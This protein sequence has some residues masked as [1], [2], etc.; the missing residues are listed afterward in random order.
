MDAP[1]TR[2]GAASKIRPPM[3][4]VPAALAL[5]L[6]ASCATSKP[7]T[8]PAP[9]GNDRARAAVRALADDYVAA[10]TAT[11]PEVAEANGLTGA[12]PD[13]LSD[14]SLA[15]LAR[16]EAR[17]DAWAAQLSAI[18]GAALWGTPE[19][20][21][22]GL[23]QEDLGARRQ[24]RVCRGELWPMSQ[25]NG[26]Q[27]QLSLLAT[28]QRTGTPELRAAALRRFGRVPTSLDTEIA[29]AREGLRL[30]YSIPRRAAERVLEQ[31]QGLLVPAKESPLFD[32]A[33]RDG[34]PAFAAEWTALLDGQI[35]PAITRYRDFLR[36]EYLPAAR[37]DPSLLK[38]RDG[39][40]C[41]RAQFRAWTTLDRPP[42]ETFRLG[43]ARV[44][45][46]VE[47]AQAIARETL[48]V[49]A[50]PDILG[51]LQADPRN[52]FSSRD[53]LAAFARDSVSRAREAVPRF[54][55][56]APAAQVLV[57]PYPAQLEASVDG[58]YQPGAE[59]GSRP[60]T[61]WINLGEPGARLRSNE[62][63]T[64]F[65]E[66]Y[67]GH[68][69]QLSFAYQFGP[70]HPLL[71]LT[72]NSGYIEGW[73]RYA[74]GLAEEMGLYSSPLGRIQRRLWPARGMV[75]DP[76]LH[77]L[78]WTR[79]QAV[80]F[81]AESGRFTRKEAE[82]TIER[83]A[84]LPAQLTAYDTGALEIFA[85]RDEARAALGGRFDLRA[86]H[87]AVLSSGPVTLP[88]LRQL[89]ERW[90]Q[91]QK[92]APPGSPGARSAP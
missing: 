76:G 37:A 8:A 2:G 27:V 31:V 89:V 48:G 35:R 40:A 19:W 84:V 58:S 71:R 72:G 36:D 86:F 26:W 66:A 33:R 65:H 53:E 55:S 32:P 11:F 83:I 68:H 29:S 24:L 20:A 73:A 41:Y 47:E 85:L 1:F 69:L 42:E 57:Q 60:G 12:A 92:A 6:L 14:N 61:Y 59:D 90:I 79:D 46:S 82:S 70:R 62:E 91:D 78:G 45:Q 7:G 44:K 15:A 88:M 16:W 49:T 77:C 56:H 87:D 38:N 75:V 81:I 28:L 34:D 18:D 13:G 39:A 5:C 4:R 63:L 80:Q 74:E 17:E 64:A 54:F 9:A 22:H 23:L 3:T 30:G 67:P 52:H 51:K 21:L 25:M 10:F 43:Q 50:L